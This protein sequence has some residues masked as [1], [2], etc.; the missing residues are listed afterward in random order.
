[1]VNIKI[2][3]HF[4]HPPEK[5]H[6]I[7]FVIAC[8]L[9]ITPNLVSHPYRRHQQPIRGYKN[10]LVGTNI[11]LKNQQF[12]SIPMNSLKGVKYK[13]I[14]R[15]YIKHEWSVKVKDMKIKHINNSGTH[16]NYL[17]LITRPNK[18]LSQISNIINNFSEINWRTFYENFTP[19]EPTHFNKAHMYKTFPGLETLNITDTNQIKMQTIY[20][21]I[22]KVLE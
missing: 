9:K 15:K 4:T 1:M 8:D 6:S 21:A 10:Y 22:S 7:N 19:T 20:S 16:H 5:T 12:F 17:V 18:K 11:L 2:N 14:I 13:Y 3:I